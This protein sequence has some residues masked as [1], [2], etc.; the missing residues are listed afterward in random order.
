MERAG[1][2][3]APLR[4]KASSVKAMHSLRSERRVHEVVVRFGRNRRDHLVR[5]EEYGEHRMRTCTPDAAERAVVRAAAAAQAHAVRVH[6]E[7]RQQ[8]QLGLCD[9]IGSLQGAGRLQD[10]SGGAYQSVGPAVF[11]PV[12]IVVGKEN[13][14]Q[15]AGP[16][17]PHRLDERTGTGLRA[18][19]DV[20]GDG[21]VVGVIRQAA[22]PLRQRYCRGLA[23]VGRQ[24][25]P[26]AQDLCPQLRLLCPNPT[27]TI[28]DRCI[29][30]VMNLYLAFR[31][32]ANAMV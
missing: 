14:Y 12:Q 23:L 1:R 16:G 26:D 29:P 27:Q 7:A 22:Y 18:H 13:G 3:T 24:L 2:N 15:H 30:G 11:G 9:G 6:R 31:A 5:I 4:R 28:H 19:G 17:V 20:G 10:P 8:Y 25:S 21:S 32:Y